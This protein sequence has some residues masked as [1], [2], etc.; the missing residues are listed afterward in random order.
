MCIN[1]WIVKTINT[2]NC[3]VTK[4]KQTNTIETIVVFQ[5]VGN[6]GNNANLAINLRLW[7]QRLKHIKS[8]NT[9]YY[10]FVSNILRKS[11]GEDIDFLIL[12]AFYSNKDKNIAVIIG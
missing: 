6:F 7:W 8:F 10:Y 3:K 1:N 5:I 9:L 2:N 4:L 12:I 11:F